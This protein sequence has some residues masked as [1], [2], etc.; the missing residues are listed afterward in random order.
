M[1]W[2]AIGAIAEAS[3]AFGV[4]ISLLY[5]AIQIR[6]QNKESHLNAVNGMTSQ[7]N[8]FMGDMATNSGL[9]HIWSIGL[10]D[11]DVLEA[12]EQ[13]QLSTHFNRIFRIYESMFRQ[14][15]AGRLDPQLWEG[16]TNSMADFA[17]SP[18]VRSWWPKRR[19]WYAE[20][21][22]VYIQKYID[23][24]GAPA[25]VYGDGGYNLASQNAVAPRR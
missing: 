16:L 22:R 9:A 7:W 18:G 1:N 24:I 6:S 3:S 5:L 21:F 2:D 10:H 19:H 14:N 8:A 13:V 25:L 4:I 15:Q 12:S 23:E 20:D 17:K 11:F